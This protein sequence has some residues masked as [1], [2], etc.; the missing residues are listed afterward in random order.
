MR[1][2]TAKQRRAVQSVEDADELALEYRL[3][4]KLKKGA[5]DEN[6]Y[7]KLTGTEDLL[8][9]WSEFL[10]QW[11]MQMSWRESIGCW[12]SWKGVLLMKMNFAKL[13][14]TEDLLFNWWE[15]IVWSNSRYR[16][17]SKTCRSIN[18]SSSHWKIQC[19]ELLSYCKCKGNKIFT[20]I[21]GS[22]VCMLDAC[23][24]TSLVS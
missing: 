15:W 5:I 13:T 8:W 11:K 14:V 1:K 18:S 16:S 3:L 20:R 19:R 17:K 4:K 2:K 10:N 24:V 23:L 21:K 22:I 9:D 7:A 12:R 6:E